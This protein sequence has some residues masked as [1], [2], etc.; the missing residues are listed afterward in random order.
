MFILISPNL[1]NYTLLS[2][3]EGVLGA[4][5]AEQ[6]EEVGDAY[7]PPEHNVFGSPFLT[8][9]RRNRLP[10]RRERMSRRVCQDPKQAILYVSSGGSSKV[11]MQSR[12][13]FYPWRG[14]AGRDT[15]CSVSSTA[16]ESYTA[17][18]FLE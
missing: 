17:P 18:T 2:L 5:E 4:N 6:G 3:A 11:G 9:W 15:K 16:L 10:K 8:S 13:L 7:S 1:D 12:E 14:Q